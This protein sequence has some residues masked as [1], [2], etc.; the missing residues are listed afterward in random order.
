MEKVCCVL[1][2]IELTEPLII[3]LKITKFKEL[4]GLLIKNLI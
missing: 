4:K 2:I 3:F 1:E